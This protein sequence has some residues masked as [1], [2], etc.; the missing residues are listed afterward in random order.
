MVGASP[1]GVLPDGLG[2]TGHT[3]CPICLVPLL[4]QLLGHRLEQALER[5]SGAADGPMDGFAQSG[6]EM[7]CRSSARPRE[8]CPITCMTNVLGVFCPS[9]CLCAACAN[10]GLLQAPLI[11]SAGSLLSNLGSSAFRSRICSEIPLSSL[12]HAIRFLGCASIWEH[13]T[14]YCWDVGGP[15][16][17]AC[18]Q[19]SFPGCIDFVRRWTLAA[20]APEL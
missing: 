10:S 3:V 6:G 18:S 8:I 20:S 13:I 11:Q 14:E 2:L 4:W 16:S 17:S 12:S 7:F 19:H 5:R 9:A 15:Q 1:L